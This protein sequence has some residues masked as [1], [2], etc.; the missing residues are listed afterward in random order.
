MA[1]RDSTPLASFVKSYFSYTEILILYY[2]LRN[3]HRGLGAG[4][5]GVVTMKV[6]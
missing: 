3:E 5:V 2:L 1:R 6:I 4:G